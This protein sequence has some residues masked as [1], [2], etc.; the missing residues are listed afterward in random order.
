MPYSNGPKM[1]RLYNVSLSVLTNLTIITNLGWS[2]MKPKNIS[3]DPTDLNSL[4]MYVI[5]K[6]IAS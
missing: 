6:N 4:T 3:V 2:Y 5:F 1:E